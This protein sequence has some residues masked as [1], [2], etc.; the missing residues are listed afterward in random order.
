MIRNNKVVIFSPFVNKHY[1]NSW[2]MND[3]GQSYPLIDSRDGTALAYYNEKSN[4]CREEQYVDDLSQ[5]WAN[6]NIICNIIEKNGDMSKAQYWG[7]QFLLQMKDMIVETC[8]NREV[9]DCSFFLN[10]RDYPQLKFHKDTTTLDNNGIE[11]VDGRPVEPYGF[12][13]V[14]LFIFILIV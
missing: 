12:I 4:Y 1:R 2:G 11:L 13:F 5:W 7:D 6:G 14:S 9:P 10:K 3:K 8:S